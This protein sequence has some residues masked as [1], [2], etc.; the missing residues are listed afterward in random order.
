MRKVSYSYSVANTGSVYIIWIEIEYHIEVW[1]RLSYIQRKTRQSLINCTFANATWKACSRGSVRGGPEGPWTPQNSGLF[2]AF[3]SENGDF[4][5]FVTLLWTP[6]MKILTEPLYSITIK[7]L[8]LIQI[9]ANRYPP[10][11]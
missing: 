9:L 8:K 1:H 2:R 4:V 10:I 3:I 6:R 11:S 7:T 5:I